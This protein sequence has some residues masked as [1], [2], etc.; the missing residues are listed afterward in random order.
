MNN[1]ELAKLA[2]KVLKARVKFDSEL[3]STRRRKFPIQ[4]FNIFFYF[5]VEY[6]AGL[7]KRNWIHRDVTREINGIREYLELQS[8]KTPGEIIAKAD[9]MA[10]ILFS[11]YDPY[12]E[13]H[14]PPVHD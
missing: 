14:E 8:F 1:D 5:F 2:D 4:A 12:F 7:G 11:G 6:A 10:V 13:G 9:R 3:H